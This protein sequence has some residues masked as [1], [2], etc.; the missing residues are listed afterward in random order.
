[1]S[2][3]RDESM[4]SSP[5][6]LFEVYL[7][8]AFSEPADDWSTSD[9]MSDSSPCL[10]AAIPDAAAALRASDDFLRYSRNTR[11]RSSNKGSFS[12]PSLKLYFSRAYMSCVRFRVHLPLCNPFDSLGQVEFSSPCLWTVSPQSSHLDQ[13]AQGIWSYCIHLSLYLELY[14]RFA[15]S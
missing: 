7:T 8:S 11:I 1:M 12:S 5:L 9:S 15:T 2:W 13:G 14:P 6:E 3:A 10:A 4:F